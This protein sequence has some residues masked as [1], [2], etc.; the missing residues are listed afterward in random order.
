MAID[1]ALDCNSPQTTE[2]KCS[3]CVGLEHILVVKQAN[4]LL[5]NWLAD[6]KTAIYDLENLLNQIIDKIKQKQKFK[7]GRR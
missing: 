1:F 3:T 2:W 5:V 7:K 4:W 6:D